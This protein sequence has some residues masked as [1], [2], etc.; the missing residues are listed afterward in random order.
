MQRYPSATSTRFRVDQ[1]NQI[2]RA[3][4]RFDAFISVVQYLVNQRG[5]VMVVRLREAGSA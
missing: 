2:F 3:N 4:D 5:K 1:L